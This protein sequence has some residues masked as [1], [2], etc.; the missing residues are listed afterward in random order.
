M[1]LTN[2]YTTWYYNIITNPNRSLI[3]YYETHHILPKSLGGDDSAANLVRLPAR[4]HFICHWLLCKMTCGSDQ[5][6]M[7]H[8]FWCMRRKGK[9]Q[10]RYSTPIT[11]RAYAVAKIHRS[12]ILSDEMRG[13]GNPMYGKTGK[14]APCYGRTGEKHPNFGKKMSV[15]SSIKKSAASKGVPKSAESNAKRSISHTG[16]K[17]EYARGDLN[18]MHRPEVVAKLMGPRPKFSCNACS[19]VVSNTRLHSERC[20]CSSSYTAL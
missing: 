12:K 17:H 14:L 13:A 18:V 15:E 2:K 7:Y 11:A 8:A 16:K 5:N 20:G 6:K 4:E 9:G 1:Y 19:R 10:E 3:G